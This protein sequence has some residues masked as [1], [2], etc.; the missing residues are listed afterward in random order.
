MAVKPSRKAGMTGYARPVYVVD[1]ARSPFLRVHGRPGPFSAA[2]LAVAV[3]RGLLARQLF[4]AQ[5]LDEV[6]LGCVI[7]APDETNIARVVSLRLGCGETVP[8]WTVQRNCASGMQ[9]LA[10]AA[11]RISAGYSDLILAGGTESMSHAPVMWGSG[12]VGMLADWQQARQF[13][14]K[15]KV[16]SRL[17]PGH[18]KPIIGLLQGLTDPTTG[19]IMGQTAENLAARFNISRTAM[20]DFALESHA[21]LAAA[22]DAGTLT[23]IIPLFTS[24]G[25]VIETDEGLRRNGSREKLAHLKPVFD[26]TYGRVTAANSAQITDGAALLLLAG[27][28]A[29]KKHQLPV[30]GRL[31][32]TSWAGLPPEEMGLG[33][34]YAMDLLLRDNAKA[35]DKIALW[36][37][38]EAFA[39]Q[40][41]AC[42]AAIKDEAWQQQEL[43]H[44]SQIPTIDMLRLNVDGGAVAVG[45]PVG[46]SGARIVL[47][48]L[49]ALRKRGGG[50]G[51]ASLCIG[52][53]QGGAM[54]VETTG[55]AQ[56]LGQ[57]G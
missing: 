38:N 48:L 17:R 52:G 19:L 56:S 23:E 55:E 36:E 2:D 1:G 47:H 35:A 7:P 26:K 43:G 13:S 10:T 50:Q 9:A 49:N 25:R 16:I 39:G 3:G 6:I 45:H 31:L 30:L 57:G 41:L 46:A 20:D 27:E 8:A 33:P 28:A 44:R 29:V 40:V 24:D 37:I 4:S 21:R 54:L 34:V 32:A 5:D 53:G 15:L 51:I 11:E 42:L 18:F 22:V 12:M 14:Q